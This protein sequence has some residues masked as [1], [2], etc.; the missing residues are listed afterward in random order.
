[1]EASEIV[2]WAHKM[3]ISLNSVGDKIRYAPKSRTP[4]ELVRLLQEHKAEVLTLLSER[5]ECHNTLTPHENHEY[6]WECDPETC[7]CYRH[8]GYPR[9]CQ[10]IPYRWV[11][12]DGYQEKT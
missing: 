8:F 5:S 12:P 3:G 10:G 2:E 11:W 9:F 1:M 6:P 4:P 7:Y